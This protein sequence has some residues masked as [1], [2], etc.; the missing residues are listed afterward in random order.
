[1]NRSFSG[2]LPADTNVH[3]LYTLMLA[4]P[5][6]VPIDGTLPDRVQ[7]LTIL[8]GGDITIGDQN[9]SGGHAYTGGDSLTKRSNRNTICL[10]DFTLKG[11]AGSE[12]YNVE[13][14]C[15]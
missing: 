6:A 14:S 11:A 4:I 1:M 8:F 9:A 12:T 13:I 3:N 10:R 2:T 15:V 5:N 7:E